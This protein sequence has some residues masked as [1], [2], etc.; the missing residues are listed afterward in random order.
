MLQQNTA[1]FYL[2]SLGAL[3]KI[4]MNELRRDRGVG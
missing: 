1:A 4:A 2:V 3:F